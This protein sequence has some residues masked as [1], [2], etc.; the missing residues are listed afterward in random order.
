M[1]T[2]LENLRIGKILKKLHTFVEVKDLLQ[3]SQTST[4]DPCTGMM[5]PAHI[6]TPHFL[7]IHLNI[8]LLFKPMSSK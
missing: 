6:I 3:R 8:I 2:V 5:N 4:T 7:K 1:K